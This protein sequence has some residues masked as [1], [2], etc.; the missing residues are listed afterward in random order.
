MRNACL[1]GAAVLHRILFMGNDI[2]FIRELQLSRCSPGQNVRSTQ[3]QTPPH[4]PRRKREVLSHS[5]HL[6]SKLGFEEDL[7]KNLGGSQTISRKLET[8]SQRSFVHPQQ[9]MRT[10]LSAKHSFPNLQSCRELVLNVAR[11]SQARPVS[12]RRWL[13]VRG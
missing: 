8:I 12:R 4:L 2:H 9:I 1:G 5:L 3:Y 7:L 13:N 6:T 10:A 11:M